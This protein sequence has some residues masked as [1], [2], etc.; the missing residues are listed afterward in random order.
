MNHLVCF[1]GS[2]VARDALKWAIKETKAS[3]GKIFIIHSMLGGPHIPRRDFETA[4]RNLKQA[5]LKVEQENI[6]CEADLSVRGLEPGEDIVRY[7]KE[8]NI[9][10][11]VIGVQRRSKVGKIFFGST[12]QFVIL[13]A[14]CPVLTLK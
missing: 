4:E 14:P 7:A 1:D 13:E 11:I 6:P 12:A 5:R 10:E 9:D 8:N 2:H 3:S